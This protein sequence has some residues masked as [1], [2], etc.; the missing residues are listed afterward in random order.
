MALPWNVHQAQIIIPYKFTQIS[1]LQK[2]MTAG[3][4]NS[5]DREGQ[6]GLAQVGDA[7]IS[8]VIMN[9]GFER[10]LSRSL[11]Y[12]LALM[13]MIERTDLSLP[14]EI[15]QRTDRNL[16]ARNGAACLLEDSALINS[17]RSAS[18]RYTMG[19]SLP[20]LRTLYL[21]SSPPCGRTLATMLKL[22]K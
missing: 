3:D 16:R 8:F 17:S 2:A 7:L 14:Q 15:K 22:F 18:A 19:R 12:S 9:E 6:R 20:R 10:G 1:L 5:D 11:L 13:L 4:S 21:R